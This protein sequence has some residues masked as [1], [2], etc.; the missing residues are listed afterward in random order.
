MPC[1]LPITDWIPGFLARSGQHAWL[2]C[3]AGCIA[4]SENPHGL[5]THMV[6]GFLRAHFFV[7]GIKMGKN[8]QIKKAFFKKNLYTEIF[9]PVVGGAGPSKRGRYY[10]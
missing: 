8:L 9:F 6:L 2:S 4:I 7:C 10:K 1:V 3:P 5:A